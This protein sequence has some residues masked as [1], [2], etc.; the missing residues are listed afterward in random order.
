MCIGKYSK[1]LEP[2]SQDNK[3]EG[4]DRLMNNIFTAN[5]FDDIKQEIIK[6]KE[7][8]KKSNKK[9]TLVSQYP[10][11]NNS[12]IEIEFTICVS[13]EQEQIQAEELIQKQ[14][15]QKIIYSNQVKSK[16]R[17]VILNGILLMF[18]TTIVIILIK[19]LDKKK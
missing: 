14:E 4:R 15:Q 5:N 19:F 7:N 3:Y 13:Q 2:S 1:D 10:N 17:N 11:I 12:Q 9:F 6:I 18:I 8:Y 16:E